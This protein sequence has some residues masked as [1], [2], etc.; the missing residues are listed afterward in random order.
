M[1]D[2]CK[3]VLN[4]TVV[5]QNYILLRNRT[6]EVR[7]GEDEWLDQRPWKIPRNGWNSVNGAFTSQLQR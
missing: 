6:R 1:C 5:N 3:Q 2:H 4:S 7:V